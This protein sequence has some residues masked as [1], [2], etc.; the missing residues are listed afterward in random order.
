MPRRCRSSPGRVPKH[1][2]LYNTSPF[3][4]TSFTRTPMPSSKDAAKEI[5]KLREEIRRHEYLYYVLDQPK[6][7]DAEFDKLMQRLK[8]LEAE[9]PKLITPD[10]PTHRV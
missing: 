1:R 8:Q 3:E 4:L 10:S 2:A 6:I 7:S 9:N 5:A